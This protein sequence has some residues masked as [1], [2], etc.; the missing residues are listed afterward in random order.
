MWANE[1]VRERLWT[2]FGWRASALE[3]EVIDPFIQERLDASS[4]VR[5]KCRNNY[6]HLFELC[7]F[8]PSPMTVVNP[9]TDQWIA[10][11]LFPTWD[12]H[13][14]NGGAN[15]RETLLDVIVKDDVFKLIGVTEQY[16]LSR[17]SDLVH[18]YETAGFADRFA[19]TD[20]NRRLTKVFEMESPVEVDVDWIERQG[21]DDVFAR[22]MVERF[23]RPRDR[24]KAAAIKNRYQNT[25]V[26]CETRLQ[27]AEDRYF[28][29]AAHIKGLGHPH[30]GPD[31]TSNMLVLCPNHHLQFDRGVLRLEKSSGKY[32]IK[33]KNPSDPLNGKSIDLK[34]EIDDR[35]VQYHF[36]W[37]NE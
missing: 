19:E 17:S 24:R 12:R 7:K 5:D 3:N 20:N 13:I 28:S 1:F 23:E 27:V 2:E 35:Y 31:I 4:G 10:S 22:R 37:F 14:R 16:A 21:L 18:L 25:C 8:W 9:G 26:F 34:H 29:E 11:A 32:L 33:S 30:N 6:R 36:D 15:D